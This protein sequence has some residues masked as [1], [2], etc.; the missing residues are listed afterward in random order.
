MSN[1]KNSFSKVT[2]PQVDRINLLCQSLLRLSRTN[3]EAL[4]DVYL[5]DLLDQVLRLIAGDLQYSQHKFYVVYLEK[6]TLVIDQVMAIQVLMNLMI[7]TLN[8]LAKGTSKLLLE[9]RVTDDGM[10]FLKVSTQDY[11]TSTFVYSNQLKDQLELSIV[12]QIVINQNGR[13]DIEAIENLV[14]FNV[15]LPIQSIQEPIKTGDSTLL[16]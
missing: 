8:F 10:L 14:T 7:Y 6:K 15:Y 2:I 5:P 13:F 4:V 11:C 12:N 3:V 1:F 16:A 9:I